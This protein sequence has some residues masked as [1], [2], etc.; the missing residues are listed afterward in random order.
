M[1]NKTLRN[2]LLMLA[3]A[4]IIGVGV[5]FV[6]YGNTG[7]DAMTTFEQ[8]LSI[9]L[10]ISLPFAQIIANGFFVVLLFII[11]RKR[12]NIDTI[13]CPLFI[14]LGCK[15]TLLVL[16]S[17]DAV[18]L[19]YIYLIIGVLIIG[20]GIGLGSTTPSGS[21]PYDGT[22]LE[23]SE[24]FKIKFSILRP[25]MDCSLLIIGILLKGSWGIGTIYAICTTGYFSNI[26]IKLFKKM[27]KD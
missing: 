15:L 22:V 4:M 9:T 26:F 23:L 3:S 17:V 6:V 25:I 20:C 12:V 5:S 16:P 7:A 24:R 27:I 18:V 2:Y 13:L 10:G 1:K 11:N 8:G 21:N 19:R 14:S